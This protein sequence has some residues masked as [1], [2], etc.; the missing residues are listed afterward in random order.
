MTVVAYRDGVMASDSGA[1]MGDASHGWA[2]KLARGMGG[3]LYGV[4][5]RA[6]Q[7]EEFLAWVRAGER[8]EHPTPAPTDNGSSFIV[9]VSQR[10][11]TVEVIT[12]HGRERYRDAPY[13]AIGA[14]APTAFGA[15][16][17]GATAEGA[18]AAAI[19]HGSNAHGS[20]R[21][22]RREEP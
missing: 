13:F 2:E 20:I 16:H 6:A 14:G 9:L 5:G 21:S 22:I 19:E 1:W 4:A 12:A 18:I 7:C 3:A 8:G 11:G 15:L 17:A 10:D